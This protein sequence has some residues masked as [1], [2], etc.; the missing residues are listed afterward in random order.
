MTDSQ[1]TPT[2]PRTAFTTYSNSWRDLGDEEL[3]HYLRQYRRDLAGERDPG[4][5]DYLIML[6]ND[7]QAE[8]DR[9]V[10]AVALGVPLE[11][12]RFS[13]EFIDDLKSRIMLDELLIHELGAAFGKVNG[14]GWRHGHCPLCK[15]KD[16]FGVYVADKRAQRYLCFSCRAGGDAIAAIQQ[17]YGDSFHQAIERLCRHGN[18]PLPDPDAQKK[19]KLANLPGKRAR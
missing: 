19:A 3:R 15:H 11:T 8:H 12:Q 6:V 7:A 2:L 14:A 13:P 18:V 16:C 4:T 9:R 10:R 17:A 5:R 1:Y